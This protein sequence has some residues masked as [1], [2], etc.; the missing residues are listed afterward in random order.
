MI[1]AE[2]INMKYRQVLKEI[3]ALKNISL[4][5]KEGEV[6]G[7]IGP[8]GAGKS[9]LFRILT[10]LL[11]PTGGKATV[12]GYDVINQYREVRN[13]VGYMPGK[14][15]LYQ[16][17]SVEENLRFFASVFD[18]TIQANY[19]QVK[20]IYEQLAPFKDRK[21]GALSGGMKQKLGLCCA[22]IHKPRVLF[23]D[24]PTTGLHFADVHKLI[25]ILR[26]LSDGG[27]TVVVIEHNL[28]VIKTADYIIDMGPEGG[29]GG[30][31]VIAKGTP[32]EVAKVKGSYTGQ[33]VKKYLK[34]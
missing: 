19:D 23:L 5:V 32:E 26:R 22:L 16:D 25:E 11:L 24:E 17:L 15:S 10:T 6:F 2:N 28:D 4:E 21:A 29:D 30:G 1:V 33:Y 9:T 12:G 8:D 31:T 20:D 7:L 3:V 27:N 13:I 18:T 14:F 34:K